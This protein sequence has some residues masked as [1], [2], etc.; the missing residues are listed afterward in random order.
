MYSLY[1]FNLTVLDSSGLE[2]YLVT[3]A[4]QLYMG[5]KMLVCIDH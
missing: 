1:L 2:S 4:I 5:E 3:A